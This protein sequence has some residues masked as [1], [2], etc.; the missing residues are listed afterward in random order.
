MK[1]GQIFPRKLSPHGKGSVKN[2]ENEQHKCYL[3]IKPEVGD[4]NTDRK[5]KG[6]SKKSS[7]QSFKDHMYQLVGTEG[8]KKFII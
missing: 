7:K 6:T 2:K 1:N 5:L 4:N 3:S 8:P